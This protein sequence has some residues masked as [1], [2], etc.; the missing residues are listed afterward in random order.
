MLSQLLKCLLSFKKSLC[1]IAFA[2]LHLTVY[3]AKGCFFS[4]GIVDL[5]L[6]V[7]FLPCFPFSC[8]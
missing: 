2:V 7:C 1:I 6:I 5:A 3:Q 4:F 8:L